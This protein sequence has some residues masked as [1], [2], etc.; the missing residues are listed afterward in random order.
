MMGTKI[1][2]VVG[3]AAALAAAPEGERRVPSGGDPVATVTMGTMPMVECRCCENWPSHNQ[4]R[5]NETSCGTNASQEFEASD[6]G[7]VEMLQLPIAP[8]EPLEGEQNDLPS[9]VFSVGTPYRLGVFSALPGDLDA[10]ESGFACHKDWS[11]GGAGGGPGCG[12]DCDFHTGYEA[13]NCSHHPGCSEPEELEVLAAI[14]EGDY[15][16]IAKRIRLQPG[17]LLVNVDRG[18]LQLVDCRGMIGNQLKVD[19]AK[20]TSFLQ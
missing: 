3:L 20:L 19:I 10:C 11:G 17:K 4:H 13:G 9:P 18:M 7:F 5:F 2:L 12:D 6:G 1:V 8:N 16:G 15:E 14:D